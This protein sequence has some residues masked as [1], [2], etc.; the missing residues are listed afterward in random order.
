MKDTISTRPKR[1]CFTAERIWDV[2]TASGMKNE[3]GVGIFPDIS[4][5]S[6]ATSISQLYMYV[7]DAAAPPEQSSSVQ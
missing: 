6:M 1:C 2:E 5:R 4:S 3:I 7:A